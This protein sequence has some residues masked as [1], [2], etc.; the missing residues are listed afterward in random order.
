MKKGAFRALLA[1]ALLVVAAPRFVAAQQQDYKIVVNGVQLV[2]DADLMMQDL[3]LFVPLDSSVLG[4]LGA[5]IGIVP[6]PGKECFTVTAYGKQIAFTLGENTFSVGG[7]TFDTGAAPFRDQGFIYV[8]AF[9]FFKSL[10]MTPVWD[11][12]NK[13]LTVTATVGENPNYEKVT[14]LF[15]TEPPEKPKAEKKKEEAASGGPAIGFTFENQVKA[16]SIGVS[17]DKTQSR[18]EEKGEIYNYYNL[19]ALGTL[20]NGYEFQGSLRTTETTDTENKRGEVNKLELNMTKNKIS[21]GLYDIQPKFSKYVFRSYPFQ[22]VSYKREGNKFNIYGTFGKAKKSLR[23]SNYAR[24][25][26]GLQIETQG[27]KP[28][29]VTVGVSVA[30][31]RDTGGIIDAK[32][33]NNL[34]LSTDINAELKKPWSVKTEFAEGVADITG[35]DTARGQARSVELLYANKRVNWRTNFERISSDFYSETSYFSRGR[36]EFSSLYNK[37]YSKKLTL[38][39]GYKQKQLGAQKTYTYPANLLLTPFAK[40][41]TSINLTRTF[42]KTIASYGKIRDTHEI[43]ISDTLGDTRVNVTVNRRKQKTASELAFRNNYAITLLKPVAQKMDCELK[44]KRE[45]WYHDRN[46][47]TRQNDIRFSYE[48]APWTE[49]VVSAG[50]FYNTPESAFTSFRLG[51]QKMDIIN[52]WEMRLSYEFQNYREYNARY[53]EASYSFYK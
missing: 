14:S 40:R 15:R 47:V 1:A 5:T 29:P 11:E 34:T 46:S 20:R 53:M 31:A 38:G 50:R 24:Y 7:R 48:I 3:K 13:T 30:S 44:V 36:T 17:G 27:K 12:Q 6:C 49:L 51:F 21:L 35:A 25:L 41:K 22:G 37:K 52:D 43:K 28:R 16:L 26:S 9:I 23:S 32:K 39:G 45:R 10:E 42:E 4:A 33:M 18:T 19:R 2:T 8:P